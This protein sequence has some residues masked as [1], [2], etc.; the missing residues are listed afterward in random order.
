MK[1][2]KKT[3]M[4]GFTTMAL[5]LTSVTAFAASKYSTPAEVVAG[6][7]GRTEESVIAE[8]NETDKTYGSIASE[9]GK[10]DE[11]KTEVLEI[12][13]EHLAELVEAGTIT[14]ERAD[15]IIEALEE[16]Q[17]N[18]DG[19]G[20]G[21][22]GK[23]MGAKFGMNGGKKGAGSGKSANSIGRGNGGRGMGIGGMGLQDG[24]C[25]VNNN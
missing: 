17:K 20:N 16:N 23:T 18:C 12:K 4:I 15:T 10:L 21:G 9:A 3:S 6:I 7:T 25:Y 11:F 19:T 24:S 13:T 2:W 8:R 14:Q 5:S 1:N 22:I